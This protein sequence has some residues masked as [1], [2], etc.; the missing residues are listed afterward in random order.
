MCMPGT[1][2]K[3]RAELSQRSDPGPRVSCRSAV[4]ETEGDGR[5]LVTLASHASHAL[6]GLGRADAVWLSDRQRVE[7][8][9]S[10]NKDKRTFT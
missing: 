9:K 6:L 2:L 8:R 5:L 4:H 3:R 1:P 10:L 7:T